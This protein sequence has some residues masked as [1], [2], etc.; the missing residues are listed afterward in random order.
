MKKFYSILLAVCLLCGI[1][2]MASASCT[3]GYGAWTLSVIDRYMSN[4]TLPH[5]TTILSKCS[6]QPVSNYLYTAVRAQYLYDNH[7][8][9][10][11]LTIG[12]N[13]NFGYDIPSITATATVLNDEAI[14]TYAEGRFTARCGNNASN[15]FVREWTGD[16]GEAFGDIEQ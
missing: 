12:Y 11:P 5:A 8:Y 13:Y 4:G 3:Q 1:G 2:A 14:I 15:A 10:E 7:Y 6:C 9:W 16:S